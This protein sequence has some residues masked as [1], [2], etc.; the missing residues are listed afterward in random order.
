MECDSLETPLKLGLTE[1]R[2]KIHVLLYYGRFGEAFI[3]HV[4]LDNESRNSKH[5]QIIQKYPCRAK[6]GAV[7]VVKRIS[8]WNTMSGISGLVTSVCGNSCWFIRVQRSDMKIEEADDM[9]LKFLFKFKEKYVKLY[10]LNGLD[11]LEDIWILW[12]SRSYFN[13]LLVRR[14]VIKLSGST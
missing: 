10:E 2:L 6:N 1:R 11:I 3:P 7:L 4:I 8:S 14:H 13:Y 9:F 5:K 12:P